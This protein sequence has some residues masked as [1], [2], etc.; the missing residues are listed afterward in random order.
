VL[1]VIALPAYIPAVLK[2]EFVPVQGTNHIPQ[3]INI[4]IGHMPPGMWAFVRKSEN[5]VFKSAQ[6]DLFPLQLGHGNAVFGP[7]ELVGVAGDLVKG[8][9]P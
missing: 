6:T 5:F 4:P 1:E 9:F 3:G 2:A 8:N 7:G